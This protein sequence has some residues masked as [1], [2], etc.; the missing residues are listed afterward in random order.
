[1]TKAT[2]PRT[3]SSLP[4][5]RSLNR[6]NRPNL[7]AVA[8][9]AARWTCRCYRSVGCLRHPE[10]ASA[11]HADN[12]GRRPPQDRRPESPDLPKR[13]TRMRATTGLFGI[14]LMVS[15]FSA[16]ADFS[17]A[18]A[19][20]RHAARQAG[21]SVSGTDMRPDKGDC[22]KRTYKDVSKRGGSLALAKDGNTHRGARGKCGK[23]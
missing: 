7:P 2:R 6:P 15:S 1:M 9:A 10:S 17:T 23:N 21:A 14:F 3:I 13:K 11:G 8:E 12:L 5:T 22:R 20:E 16:I 19:A 4:S 18:P